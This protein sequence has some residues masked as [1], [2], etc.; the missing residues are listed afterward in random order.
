M[1]ASTGDGSLNV[2]MPT[3]SGPYAISHRTG[4]GST[5]IRLPESPAAALRMT[6]RTGA[7]SLTVR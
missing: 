5:D 2:Q 4:D 1:V 7:G 6:L 3:G